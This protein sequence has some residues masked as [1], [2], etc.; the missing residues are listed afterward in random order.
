V[1]TP[2][3]GRVEA[4]VESWYPGDRGGRAIARVLFGDADPGG[5]LPATFPRSE[6]DLPT[7]GDPRR[8]PGVGDVV[9]YSEGLFVGYRWYDRRKISPAYPFGHGLSYTRFAL[10]APRVRPAGRRTAARVSIRVRNLGRRRGTAVPQLY[11]GLPAARGRPQPPRQLKG[12]AK[13][14][15]RPGQARRVHFALGARAFAHW[16]SR[17][18]RWAIARGCYRLWVGRSSR[19]L[20]KGVRMSIGA[21]CR[22]ATVA[23][24][25]QRS[26]R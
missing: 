23:L 12:F 25:L 20:G 5:R 10:S 21:R 24:A 9:H 4:I 2:W 7:A 3:R 15:L 26:V 11:L 22:G 8:Y 17:R 6:R 18:D 16:D 19:A 14:E 1:L 13:L